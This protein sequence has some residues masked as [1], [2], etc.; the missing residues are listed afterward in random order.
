MIEDDSSMDGCSLG[1]SGEEH[2]NSFGWAFEIT[3]SHCLKACGQDDFDFIT[4]PI[5][6]C[7]DSVYSRVRTLF[8]PVLLLYL[9]L[10]HY[11]LLH[12]KSK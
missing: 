11:P 10:S 3:S 9:S 6:S 4:L 7:L 2:L 1:V 8:H 5:C 12:F